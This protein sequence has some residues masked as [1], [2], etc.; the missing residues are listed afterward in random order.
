MGTVDALYDRF[1]KALGRSL[2]TEEKAFLQWL[3]QKGEQEATETLTSLEKEA[4]AL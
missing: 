2:M 1:E 3:H 4:N